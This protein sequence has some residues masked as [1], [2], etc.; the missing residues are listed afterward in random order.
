MDKATLCQNIKKWIDEVRHADILVGIPSCNNARTIPH[1]VRAVQAGL[2]KYFPNRKAVLVNS[3]C[4]STDGTLELVRDT[5]VKD[6]NSIL[7]HHQG[8]PVTKLA[9]S[10]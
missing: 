6:F 9:T 7:I 2:A 3:D 1:V 5:N 10:Y 8:E 4:G